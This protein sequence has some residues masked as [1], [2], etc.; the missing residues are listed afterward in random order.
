MANIIDACNDKAGFIMSLLTAVYVIATGF[1]AWLTHRSNALTAKGMA[2]AVKL[3]QERSKPI[4]VVDFAPDIPFFCLRVRNTGQTMAYNIRFSIS[5]E[6]KI[7]LGGKN[8]VPAVKSESEINF[9]HNGISS[10]A[11]GAEMTS[12]LGTLDRIEESHGVLNFSGKVHYSDASKISYESP[13]DIDLRVYRD[14]LYSDR[15]GVDDIAKRLED[16][17]RELSHLATGFSK[18]FVRTQEIQDYRREEEEKVDRLLKIAEK[19]K[20]AEQGVA[21]QRTKCAVR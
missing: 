17:H 19:K 3:E 6:P 9:V 5:P 14:L 16:I 15:K 7:C 12:N 21:V 20:L 13:V 4:I 11:P 2:V 18:P 1:I 8:S 10:L